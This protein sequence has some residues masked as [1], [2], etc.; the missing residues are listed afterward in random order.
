MTQTSIV[1]EVALVS[2]GQTLTLNVR[3]WPRETMVA[4]PLIIMQHY[5]PY[6]SL[7]II[8]TFPPKLYFC[9][10]SP[11]WWDSIVDSWCA[12]NGQH[13]DRNYPPCSISKSGLEKIHVTQIITTIT[14]YY[15]NDTIRLLFVIFMFQ[16]HLPHQITVPH[17]FSHYCVIW[18]HFHN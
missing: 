7:Q 13:F 16:L 8:I 12:Y 4:C 17:V 11:W 5:W 18:R 10:N 14:R 9:I 6:L 15:N 3:V 2:R 1:P